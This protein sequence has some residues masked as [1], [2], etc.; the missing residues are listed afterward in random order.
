VDLDA[1]AK[2][3]RLYRQRRAAVDAQ[4]RRVKIA[5]AYRDRLIA[6]RDHRNDQIA[7]RPNE[8]RHWDD[9]IA[10]AD[11]VILNQRN[12]LERMER[13]LRG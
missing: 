7:L 11:A 2:A 12:T 8:R 10:A 6:Q 3:A 9:K 5:V 1:I 4:Q 13:A